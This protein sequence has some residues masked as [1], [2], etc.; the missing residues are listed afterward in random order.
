MAK[1]ARLLHCFELKRFANDKHSSLFG[2]F[3]SY[4]ENEVLCIGTLGTKPSFY[5]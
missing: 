1:W 5:A 3:I 2:P 4:K